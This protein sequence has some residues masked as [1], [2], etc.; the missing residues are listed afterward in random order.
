VLKRLGPRNLIQ[1]KGLPKWK[2]STLDVDFQK[3]LPNFD[4]M[5]LPPSK[6]KTE[7]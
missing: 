6:L 7:E 4:E 2:F 1:V 3:L 5:K